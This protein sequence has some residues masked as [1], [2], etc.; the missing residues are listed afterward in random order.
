MSQEWNISSDEMK[1]MEDFRMGRLSEEERKQFLQKLK[2]DLSFK[3]K[4]EEFK[5]LMEGIEESAL[6]EKLN[7]FHEEI[8]IK[9]PGGGKLF[10]KVSFR[11]FLIAA[12]LVL[13]I[14]AYFL[15]FAA[16]SNEKIFDK[17]FTP[18]RGL[19]TTMGRAADN[20]EFYEAMVKY[21]RKNYKEAL[22]KWEIL[23]AKAPENDTLNYFIGLAHLSL[24]DA[25]DAVL[26]LDK[27]RNDSDSYFYEDTHYYLALAYI[28]MGEP[29]EAIIL[30]QSCDS[31]KCNE[32][33]KELV[34]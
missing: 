24:G 8:H 23:L 18:D 34:K 4:F 28:K 21:K 27:I 19:A 13:V 33:L 11:I 32:L 29:K 5:F 10:N 25:K 31:K 2:T 12:S 14:G 17:Y 26:Y 6:R 15:F 22:E 7:E 1:Q 9:M 16:D 3:E 30:L 20:Y